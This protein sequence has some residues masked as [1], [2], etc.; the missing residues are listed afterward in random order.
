[1]LKGSQD[2]WCGLVSTAKTACLR[3]YGL[4]CVRCDARCERTLDPVRGN[5]VVPAIAQPR[6]AHV[7]PSRVRGA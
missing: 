3:E 5:R 7:L 4:G 1:M 2:A 6:A